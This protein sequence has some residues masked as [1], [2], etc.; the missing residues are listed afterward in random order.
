MENSYKR[1]ID[2]HLQ[3][4]H[5]YKYTNILPESSSDQIIKL[6]GGIIFATQL[7]ASKYAVFYSLAQVS[8]PIIGDFTHA[9]R[10]DPL[11]KCSFTGERFYINWLSFLQTMFNYLP[12]NL[13]ILE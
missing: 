9:K 6:K 5:M 2:V 13:L 8:R 11:R 3:W 7:S 12:L 4:K 10:Q 1:F